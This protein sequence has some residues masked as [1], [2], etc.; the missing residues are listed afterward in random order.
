MHAAT[1]HT[2]TRSRNSTSGSCLL[3]GQ[4]LPPADERDFFKDRSPDAADLESHHHDETQSKLITE[5]STQTP[6][7]QMHNSKILEVGKFR[8]SYVCELSLLDCFLM[9][10]QNQPLLTYR[11]YSPISRFHV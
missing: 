10:A 6:L 9:Q 11:I 1:T 2:S 5:S 7:R 4:P 3:K 8:Y